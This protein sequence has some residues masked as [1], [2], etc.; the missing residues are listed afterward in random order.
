MFCHFWLHCLTGDIEIWGAQLIQYQSSPF[1]L[2]NIPV[3]ALDKN[4]KIDNS[5]SSM[6]KGRASLSPQ[7]LISVEEL[8]NA[9]SSWTDTGTEGLA[10]NDISFLTVLDKRNF[11]TGQECK[12]LVLLEA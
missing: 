5:Q 10:D 6:C 9:C 1:V 8:Q 2:G 11:A 7:S 12:K 3:N 4:I